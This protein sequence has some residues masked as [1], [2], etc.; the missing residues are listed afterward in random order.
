M[1][2]GKAVDC[3][4]SSEA[5]CERGKVPSKQ[6]TNHW[7]PSKVFL[8]PVSASLRFETERP[9][10]AFRTIEP[11]TPEATLAVTAYRACAT[12]ETML[13]CTKRRSL[14]QATRPLRWS[15]V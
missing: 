14:S 13:R 2:S 7:L 10:A 4:K 11:L 12:R 1:D 6:P 15:N 9:T 8:M 3:V 5:L